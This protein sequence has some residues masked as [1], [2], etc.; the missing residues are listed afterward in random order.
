M[1]SSSGVLLPFFVTVKTRMSGNFASAISLSESFPSFTAISMFDCPLAIHTSPTAT[2]LTVSLFLPAIVMSMPGPGLSPSSLTRHF[3]ALSAV[4][5]TECAPSVAVTFSPG[6]ALPQT[7]AF[8]SWSRTMLSLM[9]AG[10]FTSASAE[11]LRPRNAARAGESRVILGTGMKIGGAR[12][13]RQVRA[14]R[15][16]CAVLSSQFSVLSSQKMCCAMSG[17][18]TANTEH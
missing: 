13:V 7:F 2:F 8:A 12:R 10:S 1:Q 5:L 4:S 18:R 14:W 17:D 3:P 9:S 6:F 11:T 15:G 16:K